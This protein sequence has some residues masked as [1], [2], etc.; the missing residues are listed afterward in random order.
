MRRGGREEH[1]EG[2]LRFHSEDTIIVLSF[3]PHP[4]NG[5]RKYKGGIEKVSS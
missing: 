1:E 2:P 3:P 5:T 4:P